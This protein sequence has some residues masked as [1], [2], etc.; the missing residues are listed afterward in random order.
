MKRIEI[1][2]L[3]LMLVGSL[4]G[5]TSAPNSNGSETKLKSQLPASANSLKFGCPK[6]IQPVTKRDL[7]CR[8]ADSDLRF[9]VPAELGDLSAFIWYKTDKHGEVAPVFLQLTDKKRNTFQVL[10][11]PEEYPVGMDPDSMELPIAADCNSDGVKDLA[12]VT[13]RAANARINGV[14]C[15]LYSAPNRNFEVDTKPMDGLVIPEK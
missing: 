2:F 5:C 4:V 3:I 14:A 8:K 15:W 6:N 12:I 1:G 9:S 11:F 10:K 13:S 7:H